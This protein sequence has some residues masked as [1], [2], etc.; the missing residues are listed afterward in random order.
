MLTSGL[1]AQAY[2]CA[3]ASTCMQPLTHM[4]T[5]KLAWDLPCQPVTVPVSIP[6]NV[7][8]IQ[9]NGQVKMSPLPCQTFSP[10]PLPGDLDSAMSQESRDHQTGEDQLVIPTG[11]TVSYR[12]PYSFT[13]S[14]SPTMLRDDR[15]FLRVLDNDVRVKAPWEAP[16][17]VI[18]TAASLLALLGGDT[19]E[20]T[21]QPLPGGHG[22]CF[23]SED[24]KSRDESWA[25][26]LRRSHCFPL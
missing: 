20:A 3:H 4:H 14:L 23:Y 15:T 21:I 1:H 25:T 19:R 7:S 26:F 16:D 6:K 24:K 10:D 9:S 8:W 2:T 12:P 22:T 17:S 18:K 11:S 5:E 13:N